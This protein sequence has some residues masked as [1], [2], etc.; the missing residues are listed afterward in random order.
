MRTKNL[1]FLAAV[2]AAFLG[3]THAATAADPSLEKRYGDAESLVA[4]KGGGVIYFAR[5]LTSTKFRLVSHRAGSSAKTVSVSAIR[6]NGA[7]PGTTGTGGDGRVWASIRSKTG[8]TSIVRVSAGR[9]VDEFT[10]PR[11]YAATAIEGDSKGRTWLL[12]RKDDRVAYFTKEMKLRTAKVSGA[13][14]LYALASDSDGAVWAAGSSS[15]KR[16]SAQGRKKTIKTARIPSADIAF[17]DEAIWVPG[18]GGVQR[19]SK[20]GSVRL[21]TLQQPNATPSQDSH[22]SVP[23][24]KRMALSLFE[25]PDGHLG[26]TAGV[27][28]LLQDDNEIIQTSIGRVDSSGAVVETPTSIGFPAL[29]SVGR[30]DAR[31]SGTALAVADSQGNL[32]T[33]LYGGMG[34]FSRGSW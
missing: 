6:R 1:T 26:F 9:V 17:A 34:V 14:S 25:R 29:V 4:S 16:F 30:I 12:G 23:F 5:S 31:R 18:V 10:L 15:V 19:I 3:V 13:S 22:V 27:P 11:G 33:A 20:A 7:R 2:I 32:W 28:A 8:R 21:V 24:S